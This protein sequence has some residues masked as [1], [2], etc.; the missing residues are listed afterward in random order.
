[1][2]TLAVWA[3][4]EMVENIS[5]ELPGT[6]CA[7]VAGKTTYLYV[8]DVQEKF[9]DDTRLS[10]MKVTSYIGTPLFDSEGRPLAWLRR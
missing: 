3:H 8:A 1:M 10:E 2:V 9:P 5:Y 7:H 4:N 6:P